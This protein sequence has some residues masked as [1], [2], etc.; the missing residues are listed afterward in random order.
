M[1]RGFR[2]KGLRRLYETGSPRGISPA[3]APRAGR[4]LARLDVAKRPED[5]DLPGWR[6]HRLTG[7]MAGLWSVRLTANWRIVFRFDGT[8]VVDVDLLDY[9]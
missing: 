7:G 8:E 9:H 3:L 6:L 1:I 4:I 2:H 5:M